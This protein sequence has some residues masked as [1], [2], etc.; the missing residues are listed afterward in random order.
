MWHILCFIA[1]LFCYK[2]LATVICKVL[3]YIYSTNVKTSTC[4]WSLADFRPW[5]QAGEVEVFLVRLGIKY[6]TVSVL[7]HYLLFSF[8]ED[9]HFSSASYKGL[10]SLSSLQ[11]QASPPGT[12]Q[13]I[14]SHKTSSNLSLPCFHMY[15]T[16]SSSSERLHGKKKRPLVKD[17]FISH[18]RNCEGAKACN[19]L[20][21]EVTLVNILQHYL[22]TLRY[23]KRQMIPPGVCVCVF[24]LVVK[25]S[26]P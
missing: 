2:H 7:I 1:R 6:S 17:I 24:T 9:I 10:Q 12:L 18:Q 25:I 19:H 5:E 3:I 4:I 26:N 16:T 11:L 20:T 22:L 15:S 8:C 14:S 13:S 21:L 23:N